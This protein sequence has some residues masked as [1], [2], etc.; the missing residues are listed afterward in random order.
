MVVPLRFPPEISL[1]RL[2]L[3]ELLLKHYP[4]EKAEAIDVSISPSGSSVR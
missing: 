2:E 4:D 1:T 3:A